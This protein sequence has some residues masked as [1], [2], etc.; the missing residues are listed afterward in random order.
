MVDFEKH[1]EELK[2]VIFDPF[3][4]IKADFTEPVIN[5][6]VRVCMTKPEWDLWQKVRNSFNA[7]SDILRDLTYATNTYG[8]IGV[9]YQEITIA[10]SDLTQ[11]VVADDTLITVS[12][13]DVEFNWND[14]RLE[15]GRS[16]NLEPALGVE[17]MGFLLDT[18]AH[19]NPAVL[20]AVAADGTVSH[21]LQMD[22]VS[23]APGEPTHLLR[24]QWVNTGGVWDLDPVAWTVGQILHLVQLRV[25][26]ATTL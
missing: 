18:G 3:P 25:L 24:R 13:S 21:N 22:C 8:G 17:Q 7:V 19:I 12:A 11:T 4:Q 20:H 10:A 14:P 23:T 6:R 9:A 16:V 26:E 2:S 1:G 15:F 5:G